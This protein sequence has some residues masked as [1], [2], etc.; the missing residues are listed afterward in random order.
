[1]TP[2]PPP[3]FWPFRQ[4]VRNGALVMNKPP[5]FDPDSVERNLL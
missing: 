5:K 3:S 1:M 4:S 2:I